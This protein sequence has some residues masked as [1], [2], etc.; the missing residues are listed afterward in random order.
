ML[1][2]PFCEQALHERTSEGW[3]CACGETIPYGFERDSGEGCETCPVLH[4]PRRK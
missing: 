4:C 1:T 2:C 3:M